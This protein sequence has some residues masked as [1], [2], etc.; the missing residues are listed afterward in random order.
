MAPSIDSD[1][2]MDSS[3]ANALLSNSRKRT[4][5]VF[6]EEYVS[7]IEVDEEIRFTLLGMY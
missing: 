3:A 2:A 1:S 7:N 5:A 6:G 4:R